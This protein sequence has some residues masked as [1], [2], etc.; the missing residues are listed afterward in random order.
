MFVTL[1]EE[2]AHQDPNQQRRQQSK[3]WKRVMSNNLS[4]LL[5]MLRAYAALYQQISRKPRTTLGPIR[6]LTP[7]ISCTN[8]FP[9]KTP[10]PTFPI[11]LSLTAPLSSFFASVTPSGKGCKPSSPFF[12]VY[13]HSF[14]SIKFR[15][16]LNSLSV[17]RVLREPKMTSFFLAR[18]KETL[19]L[20]QSRRR[21]P[22]CR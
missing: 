3:L 16:S 20:R 12:K 6:R 4:S 10:S 18:V 7:K 1:H 2:N 21:S 17:P 19:I 5:G 9:L 22:I 14:P 8:A 13:I 11:F 15:K